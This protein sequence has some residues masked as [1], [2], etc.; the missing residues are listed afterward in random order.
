[1]LYRGTKGG[2]DN[3][4]K[5][6]ASDSADVRKVNRPHINLIRGNCR[7]TRITAP[8]FPSTRLDWATMNLDFLPTASLA[9]LALRANVIQRVRAFF[10]KRNFIEVETPIL[11]HDTCVDR[12][13]QPIGVRKTELLDSV[14]RPSPTVETM[15]LQ[16][17]PEFG[18]KRLLASGAEAIYQIT[19]SF[20]AGE[21]GQLHNP[22]F[23][24]LEWYRV[25]DNLQ[26][27]MDLLANLITEIL[28]LDDVAR[29]D[30]RSLF[31]SQLGIDPHSA[32]CGQLQQLAGAHGIELGELVGE[33]SDRDFWLHLL[34]THVIEPQLG[35][36]A[37]LIVYD[38]P[39]TQSALAF[40]RNDL[41]PVAERFEL[42]VQGMEIANGYHELLDSAE[43]LNRNELQNRRRVA[44]GRPSLPVHSRLMSA[45]EHGIPACAGV[46]L[47]VDRL[48]MLATGA[49]KID[50]V[51]AFP[52]ERA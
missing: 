8:L 37:P 32:T 44:D 16:T 17:S 46:A 25:G 24:M 38:W 51:M 34:M 43:L 50:E 12:H 27:G 41:P 3:P 11:S 45:M 5:R 6:P 28:E 4:A 9:R 14:D 40:V 39:A 33:N 42:Y 29:V 48:V 26:S 2:N 23:T 30:Y 52:I 19:K 21:R 20:R 49:T 36:S 47:G 1:M 13:L 18:M 15:W 10:D 7:T 22:E 35:F 31:E